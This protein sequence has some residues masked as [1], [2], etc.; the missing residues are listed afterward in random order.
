MILKEYLNKRGCT[1]SRFSQ[2]C[3]INYATFRKILKGKANPTLKIA[4][5]IVEQTNNEVSLNEIAGLPRQIPDGF[6]KK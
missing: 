6:W 1:A 2:I 3:D 5:K 4:M